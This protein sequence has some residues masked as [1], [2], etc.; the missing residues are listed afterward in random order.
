MP[1]ITFIDRLGEERTVEGS[2]GQSVMDVA[3][4]HGIDGIVGECGGSRAC[5]TC[6]VHVASEWRAVVG[7]ADRDE[8]DL[9]DFVADRK[10]DSRLSCQIRLRPVLD[11][12]VV[13]TPLRQG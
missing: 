7:D 11:G 12:L 9:L 4:R 8:S 3:K 5:A 1:R 13:R 6:H 10:D 2:V